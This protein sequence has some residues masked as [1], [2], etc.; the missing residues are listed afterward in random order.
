MIRLDLQMFAKGGS[1]AGGG[2]GGGRGQDGGGKPVE[3]RNLQQAMQN[4]QPRS[5]SPASTNA[6]VSGE[7]KGTKSSSAKGYSVTAVSKQ[8]T[9][10]VY[11]LRNGKET[12]VSEYQGSAIMQALTYNRNRESWED[13]NKNKFVVRKKR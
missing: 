9:Y 10:V 7:L 1:G 6:K 12:Y 11:S 4:V 3:K 5:S 13:R 8:E 2:G